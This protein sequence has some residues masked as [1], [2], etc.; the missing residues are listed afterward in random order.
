MT[1]PTKIAKPSVFNI[2]A[3]LSKELKSDKSASAETVN[4]K[5]FKINTPRTIPPNRERSTFFEYSA[6]AM[7]SKDGRRERGVSSM[8]IFLELYCH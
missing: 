8:S 1:L 3:S 7:A 5:S 2:Q 4:A 6:T